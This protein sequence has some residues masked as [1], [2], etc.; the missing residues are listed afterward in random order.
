MPTKPWSQGVV[1]RYVPGGSLDVL[2]VIDY[3]VE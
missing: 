2:T 1:L 3:V